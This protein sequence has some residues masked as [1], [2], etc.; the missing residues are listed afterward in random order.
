MP[1]VVLRLSRDELQRVIVRLRE[2][3][4]AVVR[5]GADEAVRVNHVM[6]GYRASNYTQIE[7]LV[8]MAFY[9]RAHAVF[10]RNLELDAPYR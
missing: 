9:E 3:D 4:E 5:L 10:A 1:S 6:R 7:T 2:L 8:F